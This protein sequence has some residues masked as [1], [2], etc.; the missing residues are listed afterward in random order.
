MTDDY[1]VFG[2]GHEG[3]LKT[4]EPGLKELSV[5]TAAVMLANTKDEPAEYQKLEFK[6]LTISRH[7]AKD[8]KWYN[9]AYDVLPT[10]ERVNEAILRQSPRPSS[11]V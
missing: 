11:T 3:T 2:L 4:D 8:G 9:I 6:N 10:N 1:L 7:Q 5:V